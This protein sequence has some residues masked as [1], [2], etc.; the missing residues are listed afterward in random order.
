M[1]LNSRSIVCLKIWRGWKE[2]LKSWDMSHKDILNALVDQI[3]SKKNIFL[4]LFIMFVKLVNIY[5]CLY[6]KCWF[7]TTKQFTVRI[8]TSTFPFK[9]LCL[10][11]TN[12]SFVFRLVSPFN[13][14]SSFIKPLII[15]RKKVEENYI[16]G[17]RFRWVLQQL[18]LFTPFHFLQ[19]FV[20]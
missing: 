15:W 13:S 3:N 10:F 2:K 17:R 18:N 16:E 9:T 19:R 14:E 5:T 11:R 1:Y 20:Y 4:A 12:R 6:L 8:K 7:R